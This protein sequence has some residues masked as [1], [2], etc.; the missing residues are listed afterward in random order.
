MALFKRKH[1]S[2]SEENEEEK[3]KEQQKSI[4]KR[5]LTPEQIAEKE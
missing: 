5:E 3:E 4:F 2:N 1:R